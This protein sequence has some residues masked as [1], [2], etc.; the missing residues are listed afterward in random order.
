MKYFS[1]MFNSLIFLRMRHNLHTLRSVR[2]CA[3]IS[4]CVG[5]ARCEDSFP[6]VYTYGGLNFHKA[7]MAPRAALEVQFQS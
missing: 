4:K 7:C 6:I 5:F 2:Q 1:F 3:S